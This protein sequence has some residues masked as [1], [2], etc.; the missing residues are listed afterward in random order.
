MSQECLGNGLCR[1]RMIPDASVACMG[2]GTSC[3]GGSGTCHGNECCFGCWDGAACQ[4]GTASAACGVGGGECQ[5]CG[6]GDVCRAATCADQSTQPSFHLSPTALIFR[7]M[8]GR[9][10]AGGDDS[11]FHQLGPRADDGGMIALTGYTGSLRFADM[12]TCQYATC[13][14]DADG[15]LYCWGTN[16]LGALALNS[17]DSSRVENDPVAADP[18]NRYIDVEA[19][20]THFCAIKDDGHLYCWGDNQRGQLG[21][22]SSVGSRPSPSEVATGGVWTQIATMSGTHTCAIRSDGALFC[23]GAN[24]YG[25]IGDG[26]AGTG[27]MDTSADRNTPT[28][29]GTDT[30]WI[31]V[32]GGSGHTCG[33]RGTGT[34]GNMYC[35]GRNSS[36]ELGIGSM[37]PNRPTPAQVGSQSGWKSVGAGLLHTCGL[38]EI[39]GAVQ[40]FCWGFDGFDAL[41]TAEAGTIGSAP[42]QVESSRVTDGRASPRAGTSAAAPAVATSSAGAATPRRRRCSGSDRRIPPSRRRRT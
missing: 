9:Y 26:T 42:V 32:S 4:A 36:N 20:S 40:A 1:Q 3:E 17:A 5:V 18:L 31:A 30:D 15:A 10:W 13:G 38:I 39:S 8:Q 41:G 21:V 19:G 35:W 2:E 29:V 37:D 23:W 24:G 27:E 33:I 25:Q 11:T 6:A 34:T 14:L 22:G 7:D 28:Q 12:A 16:A